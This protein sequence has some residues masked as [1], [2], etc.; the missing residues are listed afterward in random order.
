MWPHRTFLHS[1]IGIRQWAKS[2]HTK[3][4]SI[5]KNSALLLL[6]LLDE[7]LGGVDGLAVP[8]VTDCSA[9]DCT[10]EEWRANDEAMLA[11]GLNAR[12]QA[13]LIPC[14]RKPWNDE[15]RCNVTQPQVVATLE[16]RQ[17]FGNGGEVGTHQ[18]GLMYRAIEI[19]CS[20]DAEE[21]H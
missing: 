5:L 19:H 20:N 1:H 2:C 3:H 17:F 14:P 9:D 8:G 11:K 7:G 15:G 18:V 13:A 21:H 4:S 12:Q 16:S 6:N 10:N